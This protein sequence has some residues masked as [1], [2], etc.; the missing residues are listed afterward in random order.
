MLVVEKTDNKNNITVGQKGETLAASYLQNK[1]F[2]IIARNWR[3][4]HLEID[5]IAQCG[6]TLHFIEV[7]TLHGGSEALPERKVNHTKVTRMKRAAEAYLFQYPSWQ[8]IQFDIVAVTLLGHDNADIFY[9]A[10][11]A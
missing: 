5:L 6:K 8:F 4:R 2:D 9:I 7:K 3:Y 1:G 11:I 10:D